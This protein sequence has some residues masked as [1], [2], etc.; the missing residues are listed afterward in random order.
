MYLK[1]HA[2]KEYGNNK[3]SSKNLVE[4]LEKENAGID[5]PSEE[6]Y[7]FS[8]DQDR[9][10]H[11]KVQDVLDHNHKGLKQ[12][13]SKF[14]ML[15]IN[16]SQE[17]LLHIGNDPAKMK[18]YT[19]DIMDQYAKD[20]NRIVDGKPITGDDLVYF[21]KLEKNRIYKQDDRTP[22]KEV[23]RLDDRGKLNKDFYRNTNEHG[24]HTYDKTTQHAFKHNNEVRKQI[25]AV[26]YDPNIP[27]ARQEK[28]IKALSQQYLRNADGKV[29]L[30]GNQREGLNT[31]VHIIVSRKDKS[32]TVSMSPLANSKG[33]KNKLNG[34]E[35][36]IGFN[37]EKFVDKAETIFDKKFSYQR[38]LENSFQFK[39]G[40]IHDA[41]K[42][43]KAILA[44]PLDAQGIAKQLVSQAIQ[45][46]KTAKL[47]YAPTTPA[48]LKSKLQSE[49]I[50]AVALAIKANPA[51]LP[52]KVFE[53]TLGAV[54]KGISR[55]G[56]IGM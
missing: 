5:H 34:K 16:P 4:Y 33:S 8:H 1:I 50:K 21:A 7:F 9:V 38:K 20:M 54:A 24:T 45:N 14:F 15:T 46:P 12:T 13:D 10:S 53:K 6:E 42:Y 44:Q 36:Q 23:Y 17:E 47:L 49:A 31:H 27:E 39:H 26:K 2:P 18:D 11:F 43:A 40:K 51:G 37:R 35:V 29:I 3:G 19:R 25:N 52:F 28:R 30:P 32:Q 41:E 55:A 22:L 56:G 48:Q